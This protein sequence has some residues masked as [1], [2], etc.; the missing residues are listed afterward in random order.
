MG[1]L[2]ELIRDLNSLPKRMKQ[3]SQAA[4]DSEIPK[5]VSDLQERSPV[6]TG[7]YRSSWK[8][9]SPRFS[10]AGVLASASVLNDDPKAGIMNEGIAPGAAPWYFPSQKKPTGKLV[11]SGGRIW[12]GGLSPGH[13][14]TIGGAMGPILLNNKD[15]QLQIAKTVANSIIKVI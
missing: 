8:K 11:E 7:A 4:L 3:A 13:A 10:P 1:T 6:D 15:R 9:S 14:L 5:L 12:A 2:K